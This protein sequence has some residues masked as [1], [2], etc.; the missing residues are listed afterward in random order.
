MIEL[1]VCLFAIK[2]A[3]G[4]STFIFK[5]IEIYQHFMAVKKKIINRCVP[6]HIRI[7][8]NGDM[9]KEENDPLNGPGIDLYVKTIVGYNTNVHG[10]RSLLIKCIGSMVKPLRTWKFDSFSYRSN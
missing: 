9:D 5:I 2:V 1:H 10:N 8:G 7:Y 6:S 3:K 4:Q